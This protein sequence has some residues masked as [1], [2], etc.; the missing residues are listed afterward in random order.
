MVDKHA[1][2][3]IA[4]NQYEVLR[5]LIGCIDDERNDIYVH[6]DRKTSIMPDVKV[7]HAGLYFLTDRIDVCWGDY[8]QI[9][10]E[11]KLFGEAYNSQ[12]RL[13]VK[14][15]YYHLLSGVD[16]PLKSQDYIHDFFDKNVGKVFLG[17]Y[18]GNISNELKRKVGVYHP[19][20]KQ[21]SKVRK[22]TI[23]SLIRAISARLQ[24]AIGGTRNKDIELVRGTNW[25]SVTNEF[26]AFLLSRQVEIR[27][28]FRYTF[29]ADEVYKHTLCW[30]S[31]F[32]DN[33]YDLTNEARGCMREIN[34]I[35]TADKSWL[36]SFVMKD[37]FRLKASDA[38][39]ARKFDEDNIDVVHRILHDIKL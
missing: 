15:K 32:R 1:Y 5:C 35:V 10:V 21:F 14:Y 25:C 33:V 9:E 8:S 18:Q 28:R 27:K 12:E 13:N 17:F 34:W 22:Y 16:I 11:M 4:H 39:F 20:P 31:C 37:Y 23:K 6:V 36:P 19:F 24:L 38:L 26:V 7:E 30:N 3:I 29:C 2:L